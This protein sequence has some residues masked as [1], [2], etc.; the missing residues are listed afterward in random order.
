MDRKTEKKFNFDEDVFAL[1]QLLKAV[2]K[3]LAELLHDILLTKI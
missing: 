3:S 2:C 1:K